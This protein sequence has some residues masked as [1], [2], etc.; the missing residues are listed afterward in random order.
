MGPEIFVKDSNFYS[1]VYYD[2]KRKTF[3]AECKFQG[4]RYHI[5]YSKKPRELA[6]KMNAVCLKIGKPILNPSLL[7]ENIRENKSVSTVKSQ[8][9]V[10][11]KFVK[12]GS[13]PKRNKEK[14]EIEMEESSQVDVEMK[15]A[16]QRG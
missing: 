14:S 6:E 1:N 4:Q 3:R 16:K 15:S 2:P 8:E 11:K 7:K 5:G 9:V 13:P 12:K 10:K